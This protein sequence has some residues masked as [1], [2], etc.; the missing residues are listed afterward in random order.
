MGS[1]K[2]PFKFSFD[3]Y[4]DDVPA[5]ADQRFY[6]FRELSLANDYSDPTHLRDRITY[7]VLGA[8]GLPSLHAATYRVLLDHGTGPLD[9][10][11]YT[12][13]ELADDT[14]VPAVFGSNDGNLYEGDGAGATLASSDLTVLKSGFDKENNKKA[15]DWGDLQSLA[16]LLQAEQRTT[17]PKKWRAALEQEFDVDGFLQWLGI[18]GIIGDIDNY[19]TPG[20][21]H[22]FYLYD[23]PKTGQLT[24]ISWDHN[25]AYRVAWADKQNIDKSE[26]GADS[27]LIR[28]LLDDPVYAKRYAAF[29]RENASTVLDAA[30]LE[31][32]IRAAAAVV[33]P[34]SG[35]PGYDSA[36]EDLVSYVKARPAVVEQFLSNQK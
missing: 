7:D 9:L 31:A 28:S 8:A 36:I 13:V 25:L 22:N 33:G 4:E 6:G 24:W 29:V 27:P 18:A 20:V 30:A 26:V 32:R 14:G 1:L 17:D 3:Q 21:A 10:G 35:E 11:L 2:L 19:G 16:N 15:D 5:V 12:M 23:N 34:A